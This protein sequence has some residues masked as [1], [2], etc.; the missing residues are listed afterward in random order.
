MRKLADEWFKHSSRAPDFAWVE[1]RGPKLYRGR[2]DDKPA[3]WVSAMGT[4]V[5]VSTRL[6]GERDKKWVVIGE[7]SGELPYILRYYEQGL[8]DQGF[9]YSTYLGWYNR[10]AEL[11]DKIVYKAMSDV[12]LTAQECL[13]I[14]GMSWISF[15]G[16]CRLLYY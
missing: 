2:A 6:F 13:R 12:A 16:R 4:K 1:D 15:G 3:I 5:D 14:I 11:H 8:R 7:E 9:S 10:E